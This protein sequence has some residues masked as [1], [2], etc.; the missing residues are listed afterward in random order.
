MRSDLKFRHLTTGP[1]SHSFD[2]CNN[3]ADV[4]KELNDACTCSLSYIVATFLD[5]K[6]FCLFPR[7]VFFISRKSSEPA[8]LNF[9]RNA[10]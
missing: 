4:I 5:S 7:T 9:E 8:Y 2:I 3:V 1:L 6:S 10:K